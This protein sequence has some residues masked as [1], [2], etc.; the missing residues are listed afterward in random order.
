MGRTIILE[1]VDFINKHDIEGMTNLMTDDHTF[2]DAHN[3]KVTGKDTMKASWQLYFGWFP[4]YTIE[5]CDIIQGGQCIALLGFANGTYHNLNNPERSNYF[6]LPSAWKVIV[7]NDKIKQ[8]QVYADT[9]VPNDIMGR[10]KI[11]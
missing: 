11:S 3:N 8:W 6:H 7:E 4:D 5:V 9:K 1:F 10:N 2:I